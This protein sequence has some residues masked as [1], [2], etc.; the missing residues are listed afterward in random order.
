M[1]IVINDIDKISDKIANNDDNYNETLY[2]L[3]S[4][5]DMKSH[6]IAWHSVT[7]HDIT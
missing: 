2:I 6:D 1:T 4:Y 5:N 3:K 7:K